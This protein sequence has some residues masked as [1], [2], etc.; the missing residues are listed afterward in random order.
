[1]RV[2]AATILSLLAGCATL[3]PPAAE[4]DWPAR[5]EALQALDAWVL[6]GRVA[7]AAGEDGFSGGLRWAQRSDGSEIRISGPMGGSLIW[8][9]EGDNNVVAIGEQPPLAEGEAD[10]MLERLLG[11]GKG[12]PVAEMRYWVVGVPAPGV[13]AD[14][15]LSDDRRLASLAQS[16]WQVRYDRYE[17]VGALLLPSR[18]EMTTEGLRLRVI[19]SGWDL[20]P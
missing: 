8:I 14:E 17:N 5:R 11:T 6:D 3:A 12:L 1:M 7:V 4:D 16:G 13:P 2:A 18:M 10:R 15:M 19:V 20:A 9:H